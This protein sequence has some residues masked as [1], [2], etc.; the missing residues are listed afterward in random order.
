MNKFEKNFIHLVDAGFPILYV[1]TVEDEETRASIYKICS[2]TG[3]DVTEWS[4]NSENSLAEELGILTADADN[5]RQKIILL[6]DVH[7]FFGEKT[8]VPQII[9]AIKNLVNGI[10]RGEFECSIVILAPLVP[11]PKELEIYTTILELKLLDDAALQKII[12]SFAEMNRITIPEGLMFNLVTHLKGLSRVEIQ[13]I[14]SLSLYDGGNITY[15]D[16][17]K[18]FAQKQQLIRKSNILEMVPVRESMTDIGGL[19]SLKSW[20]LRKAEIFQRIEE[21]GK[22]GVDIPKGVLI[23]GMPGCGKSLTAKAAAKSFNVPLLRLDMGR[24]MGK[25][26]GES[27]MNMR[28]AIKLT[29]ASAPC[30]LWID[31]LEKAFA[32]VN[33][34]GSGSMMRL[35]GNFLTWMQEKD[36]LAFVVATANKIELPPELLRRGRFDEIFYVDLPNPDERKK[37]LQIHVRKRRPADFHAIKF[38]EIVAK[39]E[40][41]CGADLEGIVRDAVENAFIAKRE[42]LSTADILSAAAETHPL[43]EIMADDIQKMRENFKQRKLKSA[44]A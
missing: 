23:A 21:A 4:L 29:E 16:L 3:R 17:P 19:E 14:L 26:L 38:D 13:N 10:I 7:F 11:L 42:H 35:F 24:L 25:Y 18:I 22:F 1:D 30:V 9:S 5:L 40:G 34:S 12:S 36:S 37:I 27:E 44:S 33:S 31:E 8:A 2:E 43:S 28:R 6:R 41:F 32:G 20:L 39:T 15:K